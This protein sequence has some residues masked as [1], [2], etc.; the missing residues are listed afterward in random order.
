MTVSATARLIP[1]PPAR[2]DSRNTNA[3]D[4]LA[5][6]RHTHTHSFKSN[7][8]QLY[9]VFNNTRPVWEKHAKRAKKRKE[10][11]QQIHEDEED[12]DKKDIGRRGG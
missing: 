7:L 9:S 3:C 2:V 4:S 10:K 12:K 8:L 11:E 1:R 5:V 6:G